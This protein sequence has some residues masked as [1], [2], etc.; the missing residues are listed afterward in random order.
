MSFLQLACPSEPPSHP[1][2]SSES[3]ASTNS[4]DDTSDS[5][6][7]SSE[8]SETMRL[9]LKRLQNRARTQ[10]ARDAAIKKKLTAKLLKTANDVPKNPHP[11]AEYERDV[12]VDTAQL[13]SKPGIDKTMRHRRLRL[14]W[15]WLTAFTCSIADFLREKESNLRHVLNIC[16]I[17]DTNMILSASREGEFEE[18][19]S[20]SMVVSIMNNVQTLVLR[21]SDSSS[22]NSSGDCETSYR[23]FFVQTPLCPLDRT[24]ARGILTEFSGWAFFWLGT[25]GTFLHNILPRVFECLTEGRIGSDINDSELHDL[26]AEINEEDGEEERHVSDSVEKDWVDLEL[27]QNL[28]NEINLTPAELNRKRKRLCFAAIA[29]ASFI[30]RTIFVENLVHTLSIAMNMM[31]SRTNDIGRLHQ[32]IREQDQ[33]KEDCEMLVGRSSSFF[34]DFVKG[35]FGMKLIAMHVQ[36][37]LDFHRLGIPTLSKDYFVVSMLMMG[38][39]WKRFIHDVDRYPFKLFC[40][41]DCKTS[42]ELLDRYHSIREQMKVCQQCIDVEFTSQIMAY[43][44]GGLNDNA[45]ELMLRLKITQDFLKDASTFVPLSSDHVECVHGLHQSLTYR[46]RGQKPSAECAQEQGLWATICSSYKAFWQHVFEQHGDLQARQRIKRFGVKGCNQ[47]SKTKGPIQSQTTRKWQFADLKQ[48]CDGRQ[49]GKV[50]KRL[51]GWNVFQRKWFEKKQV[52]PDD[53]KKEIKSCS[54]AWQG[55]GPQSREPYRAEAAHEQELRNQAMLEPFACKSDGKTR[56]ADDASELASAGLRKNSLRHVAESR[57]IQTY[58]QFHDR[59]QGMFDCWNAGIADADGCL[60][61][62]HINLDI[63]QKELEAKW[64]HALHS[65][66]EQAPEDILAH[67]GPLSSLP[68]KVFDYTI[69]V[70]QGIASVQIR[71]DTC[72]SIHL[73]AKPQRKNKKRSD[74]LPFG[75]KVPKKKR[76]KKNVSS[77]GAACSKRPAASSILDA[78]V[79]HALDAKESTALDDVDMDSVDTD[80]SG[81]VSDASEQD[82]LT[83]AKTSDS[84]SDSV[85][86]EGEQLPVDPVSRAEENAT[87]EVLRSHVELQATHPVDAVPSSSTAPL[88]VQ[89]TQC[90][91]NVG[92]TDVGKQIANRLAKCRHCHQNVAKGSGRI[93]YAFSTVK[94]PGWIHISC[95]PDYLRS[96]SGNTGQAVSFLVDWMRDHPDCCVDLKAELQSLV[97]KLSEAGEG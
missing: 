85:D 88:I 61:L 6:Q 33:T 54:R 77:T 83:T 91:A 56:N 58:K 59:S 71:K 81:S 95:F 2:S 13:L 93:A 39:V 52:H 38:D 30:P 86:T 46:F 8:H 34:I 17:D 12:F 25:E 14:L 60:R 57:T 21:F 35:N 18:Q 40:L 23:T 96:V 15:S 63:S 97:S 22:S 66:V 78:G 7:S 53:W 41:L 94:F 48:L 44:E 47:Y 80:S 87:R 37:L 64:S 27:V 3:S 55:L 92:V 45:D 62:D 20:S 76:A 75:L 31:F 89:K 11:A 51:C 5:T 70:D 65:P 90:Q 84:S 69:P 32:L 9:E 67:H 82:S 29:E 28:N 49:H 43:L 24:N 4:D 1:E 10:K 16:V 73:D 26:M 19:G 79:E 68:V 36:C 74:A 50:P 72:V 42:D